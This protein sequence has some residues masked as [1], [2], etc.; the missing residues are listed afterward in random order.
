[1]KEWLLPWFQLPRSKDMRMGRSELLNYQTT[2]FSLPANPSL[3]Y[4]R[5]VV[6]PEFQSH[7]FSERTILLLYVDDILVTSH[8]PMHISFVRADLVV[9]DPEGIH[10]G[11]IP[12]LFK[13]ELQGDF[14][15]MD[16]LGILDHQINPK[17]VLGCLEQLSYTI[18]HLISYSKFHSM[19]IAIYNVKLQNSVLHKHMHETVLGRLQQ[20]TQ[21]LSISTVLHCL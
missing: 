11:G 21:S 8:D 1:V 4:Q 6:C 18:S 15:S 16:P 5:N 7:V 19:N 17:S 20:F 14:S 3:A 10:G 2:C 13:I 12:L 9:R